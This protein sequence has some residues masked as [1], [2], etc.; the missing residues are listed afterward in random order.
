MS[1]T[2]IEAWGILKTTHKGTKTVENS[3]LQML[4]TWF[5]EIRMY[6]EESFD[7]FSAKLNDILKSSFNL[8]E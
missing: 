7:E 4:T 5:E 2:A 8:G 6:Y 3:K 1:K